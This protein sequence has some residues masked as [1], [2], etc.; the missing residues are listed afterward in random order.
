MTMIK[1]NKV[2]PQPSCILREEATHLYSL[3]QLAVARDRVVARTYPAVPMMMMVTAMMASRLSAAD[4]N[5][6]LSVDLF[7]RAV[8]PL[9]PPL[10]AVLAARERAHASNSAPW[11]TLLLLLL[12]CLQPNADRVR[13]DESQLLRDLTRNLCASK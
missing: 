6:L 4:P 12:Y 2:V 3:T 10:T 1:K 9:L 11:S 5:Q 13:D 7:T 8:L